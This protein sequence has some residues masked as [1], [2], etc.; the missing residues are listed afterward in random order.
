MKS[1]LAIAVGLAFAGNVSAQS[2]NC[3][4]L[5]NS[6]LMEPAGYA[7]ACGGPA[8][9]PSVGNVPNVPTSTAFT[10]DIRGQAPRLAN[11]LYSFTLNNFPTQT[12]RGVTAS[13]VFGV[14]FN[15]AGTTLYGVT[16]SAG[17]P[18][19]TLGTINTTTG[20]FTAISALSGLGAGENATGLTIHPRTGVAYLSTFGTTA[21]LY[22]LNLAT[23]AA[24]LVGSMGT[25]IMIDIAMNCGGQLFAHSITT[26]SLFS[27]NPATGAAT[28][29][30]AHGLAAN[31]AQGMDFD[32][33]DGTLY[34]FIYTGGGTNRFGTFNLGTGAF[35]SLATDNP[36]GEY[37]GAVPTLCPAEIAPVAAPVNNPMGMILLGL[38]LV[39]IGAFATTRRV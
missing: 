6:P 7:E 34:A 14:D 32:N 37:E 18:A 8:P 5:A 9:N 28:L 26:D 27:V 36:L 12:T 25:D 1:L 3:A 2:L 20:A 16:G 10:I 23:G 19:S 39:G 15:P 4:A 35:T 11:T 38:M 29:I 17:V 21:Q 24:T 33:E 30:G 22:T 31:F 13:S